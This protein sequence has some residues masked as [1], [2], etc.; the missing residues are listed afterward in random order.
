MTGGSNVTGGGSAA[1]RTP[2]RPASSAG[3]PLSPQRVTGHAAG[4]RN[5]TGHA[6]GARNVTGHAA[7]ARN[8]TGQ[9]GSPPHHSVVHTEDGG[10]F[11]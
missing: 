3:L 1:T 7:G 6:A 9:D 11:I 5:V 2:P 8:V 4:A 10:M